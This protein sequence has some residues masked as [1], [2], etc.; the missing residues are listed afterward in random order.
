ML[1]AHEGEAWRGA[2][3]GLRCERSALARGSAVSTLLVIHFVEHRGVVLGA[4]TSGARP[5]SG[6][7]KAGPVCSCGAV[8]RRAGDGQTHQP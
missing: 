3:G 5:C 8:P 4:G 2:G 7:C 1:G 6:S